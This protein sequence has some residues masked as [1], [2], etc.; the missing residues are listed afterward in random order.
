MFRVMVF[1]VVAISARSDGQ[2]TYTSIEYA[3]FDISR[4]AIWWHHPSW[5]RPL[6]GL[7]NTER[8]LWLLGDVRYN[9]IVCHSTVN[10]FADAL[11]EP[12]HCMLYLCV[13]RVDRISANDRSSILGEE[14]LFVRSLARTSKL[15]AITLSPLE[16]ATE[17]TPHVE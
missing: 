15:L 11:T 4:L 17:A 14:H 1:A 2:L 7:F 12:R 3:T 13:S 10:A 16:L 8:K 6:Q 9:R 5:F